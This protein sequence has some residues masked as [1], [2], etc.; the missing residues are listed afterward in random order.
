MNE[1]YGVWQCGDDF[2][3]VDGGSNIEFEIQ[4]D[5]SFYVVI[6]GHNRETFFMNDDQFAAFKQ[7]INSKD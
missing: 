5:G 3:V 2:E 1:V 4:S 6:N 7:W